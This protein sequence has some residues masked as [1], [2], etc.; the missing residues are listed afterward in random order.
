[1]PRYSACK[2]KVLCTLLFPGVAND[3][4]GMPFIFFFLLDIF[5]LL[6]LPSLASIEFRSGDVACF[7]SSVKK[8][9]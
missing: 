4:L 9:F 2:E 8:R 3:G 5:T 1:M 7:D 6:S